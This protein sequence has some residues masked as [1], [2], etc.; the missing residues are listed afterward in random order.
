MNHDEQQMIT[1]LFDRMRSFGRVEKD[2][3]AEQLIINLAR[4]NPDAGYM[5]VQNV[6][7]QEQVITQQAQQI[8]QMQARIAQLESQTR[9]A[10]AAAP[11][12]GGFLGGLFGGRAS[13]VPASQPA[14]YAPQPTSPWGRPAAPAQAGYGQPAYGQAPMQQ[15]AQGGGF[16]KTAMATA[17]GV[18]GGML[19]AGAIGNMMKGDTA[20]AAGA[21]NADP[22]SSSMDNGSAA[23]AGGSSSYQETSSGWD[24]NDPG[25][26]TETSDTSWDGSGDVEL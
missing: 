17:A 8:E 3:Q 15:P 16:M 1:G 11:A 23:D 24:S 20:N 22:G 4:Q 13:S 21:G 7:V 9:S 12:S 26:Y 19:I 5:L 10:P 2:P 18:A 25:T 14:T 6:L